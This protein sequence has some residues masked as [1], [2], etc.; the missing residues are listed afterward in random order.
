MS[1]A[2][3]AIFVSHKRSQRKIYPKYAILK[4]NNVKDR[5][6]AKKYVSNCVEYVRNGKKNIGVITRA[7]GNSGVVLARFKRNLPPQDIGNEVGVK[8]WKMNVDEI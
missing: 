5:D 1:L 8:L 3:P 4:I 6:T 2:I 7:H